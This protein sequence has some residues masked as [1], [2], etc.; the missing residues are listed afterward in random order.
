M[1]MHWYDSRLSWDPAEFNHIHAISVETDEI[2]SPDVG[3]INKAH[4]FSHED[5]FQYKAKVHSNGRVYMIR[6]FR[7]VADINVNSE[8]STRQL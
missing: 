6:N 1:G 3:V 5:E 7:F 4:M 2:W 8:V